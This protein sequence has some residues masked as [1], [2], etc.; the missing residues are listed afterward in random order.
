MSVFNAIQ[1]LEAG[2]VVH[3]YHLALGK[4]RQEDFLNFHA[5]L[6]YRARPSLKTNGLSQ[7]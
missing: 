1:W 7:N 4:L 2:A 3:L 5:S 6:G